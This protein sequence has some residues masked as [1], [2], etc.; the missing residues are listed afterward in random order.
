MKT[1]KQK[2]PYLKLLNITGNIYEEFRPDQVLTHNN[3]NKL[4]NYFEDQDRISRIYLSGV[5]VGGG[6]NITSFG[7]NHIEIGQGFGITTDG[8][9]IKTE[10]R[11]FL[12]YR[13][14]IDK[15]DYALF[16]GTNVFEIY[17]QEAAGRPGD[18]LPLTSFALNQ[19][20]T[21]SECIVIA[22]V[23]NYTQDEGLCSGTGCDETGNKVYSNLKFLITHKSNYNALIAND[24]IY[25][26]H[27]VIEFYDALPEVCVPR[28]LLTKDNTTNRMAV[29]T[30][31]VD[32][33]LPLKDHLLTAIKTMI[34]K[35][36]HRINFAKFGVSTSAIDAYFS[37]HF[38]NA[39]LDSRIQY[40]YDL[41]KDLVATYTEIRSLI[42][43]TNFESVPTVNAFPKHL[44][45]GTLAE[46]TRL[47][48]RHRF[49]PSPIVTENDENL[50]A[51]RAL[52]IKFFNQLKEYKIPNVSSASI[53]ITPS[54]GHHAPLSE[55]AIPY[56]YETKNALVSN[57][58]P[59]SIINRRAKHQLGYHTNNLKNIPCIQKPLEYCHLDKD[60]YKIEGHIGKNYKTALNKITSLKSKY[61]L[62]FDVKPISIGFPVQ[63]IDLDN[64]ICETKNYKLLI[65]TWEREFCCIA[66]S[67]I[68]F[69]NKYIYTA[70]GT[71]NT[72]TTVYTQAIK[73][74]EYTPE[75][76][77]DAPREVVL[78][79]SETNPELFSPKAESQESSVN[80]QAAP[81]SYQDT[82]AYTI[83]QAYSYYGTS[84]VTPLQLAAV[85]LGIIDE[86]IG[87]VEPNEDYFFYTE[88]PVKII[89]NLTVIKNKFIK[90]LNHVYQSQ[91]WDP[92]KNAVDQLCT[93]IN[94]VIFALS[95]VG[96]NSSFGSN[97]HDKLY[98]YYI[99]ELSSLCCLA[100]KFVWLKEKLDEIRSSVFEDL[101]LSE[102]IEKHP[103][104]E[105]MAGVP[106]GGTFLM[107]YL[108]ANEEQEGEDTATTINGF[109]GE[110]LYD[111]ALP[112]RCCS[113]CPP[114]T[115]IIQQN[116]T[117]LTDATLNPRVF[118][119]KGEAIPNPAPFTNIQPQGAVIT[120][121][122]AP[123]AVY[124]NNAGQTVF[125]ASVIASNNAL[126]GQNITFLVDG[127]VPQSNT[128]AVVYNIPEIITLTEGN[129]IWQ[130]TQVKINISTTLASIFNNVTYLNAV[131]TVDGNEIA[132]GKN[133]T[134]F[135]LP[136]TSN[137]NEV[138]KTFTLMISASGNG[139]FANC[140]NTQDIQ[141]I[142]TRP[143][144]IVPDFTIPNNI[145]CLPHPNVE[146]QNI[147]PQGAIVS[148][149]IPGLVISAA[150]GL[151]EIHPNTIPDENLGEDINFE[152]NAG[153]GIVTPASNPTIKAYKLPTQA[154]LVIS[155]EALSW[156][157]QG[158]K[159]QLIYTP[160][161][162]GKTVLVNKSYLTYTWLRAN[163]SDLITTNDPTIFIIPITGTGRV[164][165]EQLRLII[166]TVN[167]VNICDD[168]IINTETIEEAEAIEVVPPNLNITRDL[169]CLPNNAGL[170]T[171]TGIQPNDA[172]VTCPASPAAVIPITSNN[173]VTG[174][175]FNPTLVSNNRLG[176]ALSFRVNGQQPANNV[177]ATVYK[178]PT[179]V[180]II[181]ASQTKWT[182]NGLEID[183]K[184]DFSADTVSTLTHKNY[185]V[186]EWQNES[187]NWSKTSNKADGLI[188]FQV[189]TSEKTYTDTVSVRIRVNDGRTDCESVTFSL[190]INESN[191][192]L[193]CE[194]SSDT[195][196]ATFDINTTLSE[197][198]ATIDKT[199]FSAQYLNNINQPILN[200]LS[201]IDGA[202]VEVSGIIFIR[203][204]FEEINNIRANLFNNF[205]N[206]NTISASFN[207]TFLRVDE[208]LEI[209]GLEIL[210][211]IDD[212]LFSKLNVSSSIFFNAIGGA[213]QFR[214][215]SSEFNRITINT[216]YLKG[217][218]PVVASIKAN[219]ENKLN[220]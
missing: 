42:L 165:N 178:L 157:A 3:L 209:I 13:E 71:N 211:C 39:F 81:A 143:E 134:N 93:D 35:F 144:V 174:Y 69:F 73:G 131:W 16:E 34:T 191:V 213:S 215:S 175:K 152:I 48:T 20:T 105:H 189:D 188:K 195:R 116:A 141:I 158:L 8:D 166:S 74:Y 218:T 146:I 5:G 80:K 12:Y 204:L 2:E 200:L 210:R 125:D 23:E 87:A 150:G 117:V 135:V 85:S 60:F 44:L 32:T 147:Q 64:S 190:P 120:C 159:V 161:S 164:I 129:H 50:L 170:A 110:V 153:N 115:I 54:L 203:N 118:C 86:L 198:F 183:L 104:I 207:D 202:T 18:E 101:I 139:S 205:I 94:Q 37:T 68:D 206:N 6:M 126:A 123:D 102:L 38:D 62:A 17:E 43:H 108:G 220:L 10:T 29:H 70:P 185:M 46:T 96:E 119:V 154:D 186:Y 155:A 169:F 212:S 76:N 83:D 97:T 24:T 9:I 151:F 138:N 199:N 177:S 219:L 142:T 163:G 52:A 92:F 14:L 88:T 7:N 57:W 11:R 91:K 27:H 192:A 49:Y 36:N 47:K 65:Q 122:E 67:A 33:L 137:T 160:A 40:K 82:I 19:G 100:E 41:L 176:Q 58:N 193:S 107:V 187:R 184:V 136:V 127:Q 25:N 28:L 26:S 15:A 53:K 63:Q 31:F 114:E 133:L 128:N 98:E 214:K 51:I 121:P 45:L 21:L 103:G 84:D 201:A 77:L 208:A 168:I 59:K 132:T 180:D 140:T 197:V 113:D 149:Q 181:K 22:Y 89:A 130:D 172:E 4:V 78:L 194:M 111:F 112:Y 90:S 217:Y 66:D 55:R 148:S 124:V 1:I 99:Y 56:Y 167:G 109:F 182:D 145:F 75:L 79:K 106:K 173:I 216:N 72:A 162:A 179:L 156:V 171:F 95:Q 30:Q 61:N 196:I